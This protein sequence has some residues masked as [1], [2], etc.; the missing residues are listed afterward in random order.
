MLKYNAQQKVVRG[1]KIFKNV[2]SIIVIVVLIALVSIGIYKIRSNN[3]AESN[4]DASEVFAESVD[5]TV[6]DVKHQLSPIGEVASYK[7]DYE[8]REKIEGSRKYFKTLTKHSIDIEYKGV[9]KAGYEMKDIDLS[10]D[11]DRKVISV[12]LP[13]VQVLDNYIDS[14]NTIEEHNNILNTIKSDEVQLYLDNNVEPRELE[15]SIERGLYEKAE[16][17]A[18]EEISKQL[19][20]FEKFGYTV[21]FSTTSLSK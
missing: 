16:E 4:K 11:T 1:I 14:W 5:F 15:D 17:N 12:T 7:D 8:G 13:E 20:Y 3:K 2:S 18:K 19:S 21:E 10:V 6:Y 9:I